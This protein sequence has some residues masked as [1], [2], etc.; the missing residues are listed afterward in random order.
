[1]HRSRKG[2]LIPGR[3][4]GLGLLLLALS[5]GSCSGLAST[6]PENPNPISPTPTNPRAPVPSPSPTPILTAPTPASPTV[7]APTPTPPPSDPTP[8]PPP[9]APQEGF[10]A[11][12]FSL[13]DLQ[14]NEFTLSQFRGQP[15]LV[16]FWTTWCPYC[17][18]EM[19]ALEKTYRRY[20]DEGLVVLAVN[21][22]E[23]TDTVK[24]FAQEQGLT[25]PILL[26][27]NASVTRTYFTIAIPTSFFINPQGV[28]SV[29]HLGPL[30]EEMINVYMMDIL[31]GG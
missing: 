12:D 28:V 29:V 10:T 31:N 26:D 7:P 4:V 24:P 5:T 21:V 22:Q 19:Q 27:K 30:T 2:Q 18:E 9:V 8:T 25:F 1:M 6:T 23:R 17:V 13:P 15:V 16:N 20:A 3:L 14:G 11:P